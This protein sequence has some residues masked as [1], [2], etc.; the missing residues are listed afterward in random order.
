VRGRPR[1]SRSDLSRPCGV[2]GS[3]GGLKAIAAWSVRFL[4]LGD[5]TCRQRCSIFKLL[6]FVWHDRETS[7]QSRKTITKLRDLDV[8]SLGLRCSLIS[9]ASPPRV[10]RG[11]K[12]GTGSPIESLGTGS[13]KRGSK[14]YLCLEHRSPQPPTCHSQ[15]DLWHQ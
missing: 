2:V 9:F 8:S 11:S 14:L 4:S 1:A 7:T 10:C 13:E 12:L 3:G 5:R 15:Y 6:I